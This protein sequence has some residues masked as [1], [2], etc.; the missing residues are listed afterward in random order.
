MGA[1]N[2]LSI[3]GSLDLIVLDTVLNCSRSW[4]HLEICSLFLSQVSS[5]S[6]C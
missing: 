3:G 4:I 6:V 1:I 5:M 2:V